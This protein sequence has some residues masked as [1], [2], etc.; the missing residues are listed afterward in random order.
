MKERLKFGR[1]DAC[2]RCGHDI[3]WHGRA[4]GWIDRGNGNECLPFHRNGHLITP[5]EGLKHTRNKTYR[6]SRW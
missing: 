1:Q 5:R 4:E 2:S 6:G 3:E